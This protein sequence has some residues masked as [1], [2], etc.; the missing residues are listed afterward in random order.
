MK[1]YPLPG[2]GE[3]QIIMNQFSSDQPSARA[4]RGGSQTCAGRGLRALPPQP[5]LRD[6]G[7]A[8]PIGGHAGPRAACRRGPHSTARLG[9]APAVLS[10]VYPREQA[11]SRGQAMDCK[12]VEKEGQF[13]PLGD[14]RWAAPPTPSALPFLPGPASRRVGGRGCAA[15]G[16]AVTAP[17]HRGRPPRSR[18]SA[19]G[20]SCG[21]GAYRRPES[22]PV[23][24]SAPRPPTSWQF[25]VVCRVLLSCKSQSRPLALGSEEVGCFYL[26]LF[27]FFSPSLG[28]CC[29]NCVVS[30]KKKKKKKKKEKAYTGISFICTQHVWLPSVQLTFRSCQGWGRE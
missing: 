16:V 5:S 6:R 3:T 21:P 29:G 23:V 15:R 22:T 25:V 30:K 18:A 11:R 28:L 19:A 26:F 2:R 20:P 24:A 9:W 27:S 12:P 4:S 7:A 14:R 1:S 10:V 8:L 13:C 17:W